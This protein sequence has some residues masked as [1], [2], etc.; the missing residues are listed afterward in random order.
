MNTLSKIEEQLVSN[1]RKLGEIEC[2]TK[3]S[4][5]V[6]SQFLLN[7]KI[8]IESNI[9][10]LEMQ[11]KHLLDRRDGWLARLIWSLVVPILVTF[12]TTYLIVRIR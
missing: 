5:I 1:A 10:I 7:E 2:T 12:I 6:C 4:Y 8:Q 3:D 11:R 9:K